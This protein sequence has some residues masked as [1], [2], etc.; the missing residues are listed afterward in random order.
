MQ[1]IYK[2]LHPPKIIQLKT[3]RRHEQTFSKE[4]NQMANRHMK[5]CS[6]SLIIRE[7]QIKIIMKY[8]NT[9]VRMAKINHTGNNRCSQGWG[10]KGRLLHSWWEWKLVQSLCKTVWR[11]FQKLKIELPYNSAISLLGSYAKYRKIVV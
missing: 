8:H 11:F 1:Y 4:D 7:I 5:R 10:E 6:T 9:A 3:G 2:T